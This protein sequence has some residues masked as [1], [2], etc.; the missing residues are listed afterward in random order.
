MVARVIGADRIASC[1]L[2]KSLGARPLKSG[3]AQPMVNLRD[4]HVFNRQNLEARCAAKTPSL[5][6]PRLDFL[7]APKIFSTAKFSFGPTCRLPAKFCRQAQTLWRAALLKSYRP[8]RIIAQRLIDLAGNAECRS[9][10]HRDA[11]PVKNNRA[12]SIS[13]IKTSSKSLSRRHSPKK[14]G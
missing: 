14:R 9:F 1:R 11:F 7:A 10:R 3:S 8:L 4:T 2:S 13:V 12:A 5:L 6:V